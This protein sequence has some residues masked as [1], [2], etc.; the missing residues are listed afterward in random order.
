MQILRNLFMWLPKEGCHLPPWK[1]SI[2]GRY[3]TFI[4]LC[5]KYGTGFAIEFGSSL[6]AGVKLSVSP[7]SSED[8]IGW[9]SVC[10]FELL[11]RKAGYLSMYCQITKGM[12]TTRGLQGQGEAKVFCHCLSLQSF[13]WLFPSQTLIQVSFQYLVRVDYTML[14][15]L[16]M[17]GYKCVK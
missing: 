10:D 6:H 5:C 1:C 8:K 17:V 2:L 14:P 3:T 12:V 11:G 16:P 7:G 9:P 13:P 15:S 4:C